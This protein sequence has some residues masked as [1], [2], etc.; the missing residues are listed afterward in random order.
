[1]K[2]TMDN[3]PRRDKPYTARLQRGKL[4]FEADGKSVESALNR[5][6]NKLD[7]GAEKAIVL[8]IALKDARDSVSKK[9]GEIQDSKYEY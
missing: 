5:L 7:K 8:S 4:Y 2:L 6:W 1:M 9:I 3:N